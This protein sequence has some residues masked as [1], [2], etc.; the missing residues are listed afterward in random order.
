MPSYSLIA[1]DFIVTLNILIINKN[2]MTID[3]NSNVIHIA[4]KSNG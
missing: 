2:I 1:L 4:L 3:N